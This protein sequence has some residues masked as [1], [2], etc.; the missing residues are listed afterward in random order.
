VKFP[1]GNAYND[2]FYLKL[3]K[4]ENGIDKI[5]QCLMPRNEKTEFGNF[6][7]VGFG[8]YTTFYPGCN[9]DSVNR[10]LKKY[11]FE[12]GNSD[13]AGLTEI[14]YKGR[15]I[16]PDFLKLYNQMLLEKVFMNLRL[17]IYTEWIY[18]RG[19]ELPEENIKR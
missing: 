11:G 3:L 5:S 18:S 2:S 13:M 10:V 4:K 6:G 8:M 9:A 14:I 19:I 15:F 12:K 1:K 17:Q 7:F 16:G